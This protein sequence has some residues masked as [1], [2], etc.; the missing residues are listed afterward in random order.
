MSTLTAR[1]VP[2]GC[3]S[4]MRRVIKSALWLIQ[5]NMHL[6]RVTVSLIASLWLVGATQAGEPAALPAWCPWKLADLEK[7]PQFEVIETDK[8]GVQSILFRGPAYKSL[9][10]TKVFAYYGKP[11]L[12]PGQRAPA[13]VLIH[14]WAG[15]A[16]RGW[17]Q[18]ANKRGFAAISISTNG[19]ME[20][21]GK[22]APVPEEFRG[23]G[24]GYS[25]P[26]EVKGPMPF[27]AELAGDPPQDRWMYHATADVMLAHSLLRSFPEIDTE[28]IGVWG[29]SWGG[30]HTCNVAGVDS[31]FRAAVPMY[32]CG[33]LAENGSWVNN[34]KSLKPDVRAEWIK[35]WD[36]SSYI[37]SARMPVLFFSSNKDNFY[38]LDSWSKTYSLVQSPKRQYL[39]FD[40]GHGHFWDRRAEGVWRFLD[41]QLKGGPKAPT[42]S[43]P[44]IADGKATAFAHDAPVIDHAALYY[45]TGP[46][47]QNGKRPWV[48]Q[49]LIIEPGGKLTGDAPPADA[50]AWFIGFSDVAETKPYHNIASSEVV[51]VP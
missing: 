44:V 43:K 29:L 1:C 37:G 48:V 32:G 51:L 7:A 11:K 26:K 28:R 31:R 46:A 16:M 6:P 27:A 15:Q 23:P 5:S 3:K 50:T 47:T 17:V 45:T 18:E 2:Q 49:P 39:S 25:G 24:D 4:R 9:P 35:M 14:G 38:P 33:F 20:S 19:L 22:Q 12:A 41:E 34:L 21:G 40:F 42:I 8:S 36:P 13:L 10:F 30:Y